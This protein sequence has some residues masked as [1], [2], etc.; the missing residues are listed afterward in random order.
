M[1]VGKRKRDEMIKKIK[2][3]KRGRGE[4]KFPVMLGLAIQRPVYIESK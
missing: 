4:I 3:L 2:T 1:I